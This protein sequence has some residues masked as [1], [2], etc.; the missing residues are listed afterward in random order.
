MIFKSFVILLYLLYVCAL[1]RCW[2][3]GDDGLLY[4]VDLLED[5]DVAY[6]T[7]VLEVI[8]HLH[9]VGVNF[10]LQ[11]VKLSLRLWFRSP[12]LCLVEI[13]WLGWIVTFS[14]QFLQFL[15]E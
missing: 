13:V 10:L 3:V 6:V 4:K 12:F 1:V 14:R 8:H 15:P 11:I 5:L 9:V 2:C 7:D